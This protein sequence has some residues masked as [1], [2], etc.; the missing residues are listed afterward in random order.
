M[1]FAIFASESDPHPLVSINSRGD[2]GSGTLIDVY[3]AVGHKPLAVIRRRSIRF[4][5]RDTW[6]LLDSEENPIGVVRE[7]GLPLIHRIMPSLPSFH[8]IEID[9][10]AIATIEKDTNHPS[11]EYEIDI[12][13]GDGMIDSRVA[14]ACAI[15]IVASET[16]RELVSGEY[17]I[18]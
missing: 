8:H 5:V 3:D 9:G 12:S 7:E 10:K 6:E 14:I 11:P 13:E 2:S 4:S 18:P 1:E 17:S 15:L 16:Q